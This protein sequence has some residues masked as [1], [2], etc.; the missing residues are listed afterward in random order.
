VGR[1]PNVLELIN[2]KGMLD[3]G[4]ATTTSL[5]TLAANVP[6]VESRIQEIAV[7]GVALEYQPSLF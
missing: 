5:L 2:F 4:E 7:A 3:R 6:L 1:K